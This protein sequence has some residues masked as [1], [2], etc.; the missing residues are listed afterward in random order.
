[1]ATSC[2]PSHVKVDTTILR[3]MLGIKRVGKLDEKGKKKIW[4]MIFNIGQRIFNTKR[5]KFHFF[6]ITDGKSISVIRT[7]TDLEV[8]R[9]LKINNSKEE[10]NSTPYIE[11]FLKSSMYKENGELYTTLPLTPNPKL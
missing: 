9:R 1:M 8:K 5:W 7:K 6:I 11:D 4:S 10:T 2:V 3:V